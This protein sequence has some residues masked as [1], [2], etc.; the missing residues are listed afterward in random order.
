[1]PKRRRVAALQRQ[2]GSLPAGCIEFGEFMADIL[3]RKA[4][5]AIAQNAHL[6][7]VHWQRIH[8]GKLRQAAV[9]CSVEARDLRQIRIMGGSQLYNLDRLG[10]VAGI[11][12]DQVPE[13]A[14]QITG[15]HLRLSEAPSSMNQP[16]TYGVEAARIM[17]IKPL[18]QCQ[19]C[20]FV[21]DRSDVVVEQQLAFGTS[22]PQAPTGQA[23]PNRAAGQNGPF[24]FADAVD[25][26]FEAGRPA[27]DRQDQLARRLSHLKLIPMEYTGRHKAENGIA[28]YWVRTRL[29]SLKW[30]EPFPIL[31]F[32]FPAVPAS[33]GDLIW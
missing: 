28:G 29:A 27:I 10:R 17:L 8:L 3:V 11:Y 26:D 12:S 19:E 32:Q 21:I 30:T 9:K 23:E 31:F 7:Q 25:G 18:D 4:M 5:E 22:H 33:P 1:M 14:D 2:A 6:V 24:T 20:G 16:V 13:R 15:D